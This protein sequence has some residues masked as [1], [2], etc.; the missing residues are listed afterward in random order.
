MSAGKH[1]L[2][3]K[4]I[5]KDVAEA[6]ELLSWYNQNVDKSKVTWGVAENFRFFESYQWGGAKVQE[7]GK[8]LSFS[9]RMHTLVKEDNKYYG[10]ENHF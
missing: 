4:P 2:S 10:M 8:V 9:T 3:E 6:R 1:V 7:L 5:A